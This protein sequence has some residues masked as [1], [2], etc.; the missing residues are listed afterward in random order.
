MNVRH[1]MMKI[2]NAPAG[3]GRPVPE[4]L[5]DG[6]ALRHGGRGKWGMV[7]QLLAPL[8][9][10][11]FCL[12]LAGQAFAD[13]NIIGTWSG[14]S[15]APGSNAGNRNYEASTNNVTAET[16]TNGFND[17]MFMVAVAMELSAANTIT[18]LSATFGGTV[19]TN[20]TNNNGTNASLHTALFYLLENQI[21]AGA[22]TLNVAWDVNG[23]TTTV[24]GLHIRYATYEGVA[25]SAPPA[26]SF[27]SNNNTGAT[28]VTFG[29]TVSYV[30]GGRT[31]F[32]TNDISS[33]TGI[34]VNVTNDGDVFADGSGLHELE[35]ASNFYSQVN[36]TINIHTATGTLPAN[37]TLT[38]TGAANGC[39]VSAVSLRPSCVR[40]VPTVAFNPS[41]GQTILTA[42]GSVSYIA[43]ITNNDSPTTYCPASNLAVSVT[44]IDGQT[45]LFNSSV[46]PA[47][48]GPISA[49]AS[50]TATLTVANAGAAS[51]NSVTTRVDATANA[52]TGS[53]SITTTY[54]PE[55][56]TVVGAMSFA[57]I[58]VTSMTVAVVFDADVN[59]N[60]SCSLQAYS[61]AGR[62]VPVGSEISMTRSPAAGISGPGTFSATATGL[63]QGTLYYFSATFTDADGYTAGNTVDGSQTTLF[64]PL[65]HASVNLGNKYPNN[66]G[67]AFR[68]DTCHDRNTAPNIKRIRAAVGGS[69]LTNSAGNTITTRA[70]G[71]TATNDYASLAGTNRTCDVCHDSTSVFK[72]NTADTVSGNILS[73]GVPPHPNDLD[74]I[75][76]HLHN[77]G[78]KVKAGCSDCHANPADAGWGT[79]QVNTG[80]PIIFDYNGSSLRG[81][82]F[83][84]HLLVLKTD[85]L[86]SYTTKAQW[87]AQCLKCHDGHVNSPDGGVHIPNNATV[88][89][90]Y[91]RGYIALGGTATSGS[92]EAEICWNC[93]DLATNGVSEWGTNS[94]QSGITN[95]RNY[96]YGDLYTDTTGTTKT[97]NWVT[98]YW[99]SGKGR[100]SN[101]PFWYKRGAVQSTHTANDAGT[102][103]V[104]GGNALGF[105]RTESVDSVDLIR[106]SYCHDVHNTANL[107]GTVAN[108]VS[109]KPY[110]RGT[111][112]GNPYP[113]D[114]APRTGWRAWSR[115]GNTSDYGRVP[116][117]SAARAN[118]GRAYDAATFPYTHVGGYWIDQNTDNPNSGLSSTQ[119]AGLCDLCHGSTKDGTWTATEIGAID[120]V[121][122]EGLWISG[123]NG[124]AAVV[125]SGAGRGANGSAESY[126]R[127]IFTR[128]KR[129]SNYR[130]AADTNKPA[131]ELDMGAGT[132]D[133][134]SNDTRAFSYRSNDSDGFLYRPRIGEV[135][136][137]PTTGSG[138]SQPFAFRYFAWAQEYQATFN[139]EATATHAR[140]SGT[141]ALEIGG[142]AYDS[143]D[144]AHTEAAEYN[145]Q[146]NYHT[147][148]CGKCHNPHAS[149]LP[150][151]MITNCLDTNHN[152]WDD[153]YQPA[154]STSVLAVWRDSRLSQ[155]PTAQNCHRL[156]SRAPLSTGE[157]TA[158]GTG[159]NKATPWQEFT[160]PD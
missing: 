7:R 44:E 50:G 131:D 22:Q 57:G 59:G 13:V 119:T 102:T 127:N 58:T 98:G 120:Q 19:M 42:S 39:A 26:G 128:A 99:R 110:L 74:C 23:T 111:W 24:S 53:G 145:A 41:S 130:E 64:S 123:Y 27:I 69:G 151:L 28:N 95:T 77:A 85:N 91:T 61:D 94:V 126:A 5:G 124:H 122:G 30:N 138:N 149:R 83:G 6:T 97:S 87:D 105:N 31:V 141:A 137:S 84:G 60:N 68:C 88:G 63:S 106:C 8:V 125:L 49:G 51:G 93:H 135:N 147:F 11:F 112:K 43:T 139:R 21:P 18:S 70:M 116:R 96:D 81:E 34:N 35:N 56:R 101:A 89:I 10:L 62:T 2:N 144:G 133:Y 159:W 90:N 52:L 54:T 15:N 134:V 150:K 36:H 152:N 32:V 117:G 65:M 100:D 109:G 154:A 103:V 79:Y 115:E 73:N 140:S 12:L 82:N 9:V 40:T 3:A 16:N 72:Y 148:N 75:K 143:G 136:G 38:Y 76:C 29:S 71:A 121:T 118:T 107:K 92:T 20:I 114:G 129:G 67:A 45:A 113:E 25:Q 33:N 4:G 155:W 48:V 78:F 1:A 156:D 104:S 46:S 55:N 153:D 158:R 132:Y 146:A 14:A 157:S 142:V 108:D 17:R 80:A 66:W 86:S 47:T 37:T 160:T